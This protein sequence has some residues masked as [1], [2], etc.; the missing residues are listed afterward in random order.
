[1]VSYSEKRGKMKLVIKKGEQLSIKEIRE[2][3]K[4]MYWA[5]REDKPL[6]PKNRKEFAKD[7]F[8]ILYDEKNI[9][10]LGRL[11]PIKIKFLN[12]TYSILG[13]ADVVS[14]IKKKGYGK[15]MINGLIKIC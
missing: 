6:N 15:K 5:F 8:S 14:V 4:I 2:W 9:L 10:S 1:M 3:N 7:I 11:K 12:K 13:I